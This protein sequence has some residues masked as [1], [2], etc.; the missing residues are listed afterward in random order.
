MGRACGEGGARPPLHASVRVCLSRQLPQSTH[1]LRSVFVC[2]SC[3]RRSI[4]DFFRIFMA[5]NSS[6]AFN[7]TNMTLAKAPLPNTCAPAG[8]P[9]MQLQ[10]G[11]ARRWR[12]DAPPARRSP[13]CSAS[14]QRHQCPVWHKC[15]WHRPCL[16]RLSLPPP[17]PGLAPPRR[18]LP[19]RRASSARPQPCPPCE[20]ACSPFRTCQVVPRA[21]AEELPKA[22]ALELTKRWL[23]RETR[24]RLRRRIL[25]GDAEAARAANKGCARAGRTR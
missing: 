23:P 25:A 7:R 19:H 24:S 12:R 9:S 3:F 20:S 5:N 21:A 1:A 2:S 11:Q 8:W 10:R 22:L 16:R 14:S 13:P 17:Q 6:V 4:S 18:V 15:Q